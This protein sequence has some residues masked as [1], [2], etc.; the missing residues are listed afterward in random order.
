MQLAEENDVA[1]A[2]LQ[3]SMPTHGVPD[4]YRSKAEDREVLLGCLPPGRWQRDEEVTAASSLF[5]M[6]KGFRKDQI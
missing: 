1:R 2:E 6:Q 3:T 4:S 5:R